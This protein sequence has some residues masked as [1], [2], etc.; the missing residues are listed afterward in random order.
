M[1]VR[2]HISLGG[3]EYV[4]DL[5]GYKRRDIIDFSPR[6]SAPGGSVYSEL[7]LYQTLN[8]ENFQGGFGYPWHSASHPNVY[9]RTEGNIDTRHSNA[10]QLF[11][12]YT[13]SDSDVSADGFIEFGGD[14]WAYS[15]DGVQKYV[16]SGAAWSSDALTDSVMDM[17]HNGYYLFAARESDTIVYG[18]TDAA[19]DSDWTEAGLDTDQKGAKWIQHHD[20][21]VYAGKHSASEGHL[22]FYDDSIILSSMHL[23]SSDDPTAIP[24]GHP[25]MQVEKPISYR[26][27]FLGPRPDGLYRMDNTRDGARVVID[28]R[29]QTSTAN[30][31]SL[32]VHNGQL[33]Y[34][35]RDELWQWNGVRTVPI[36]P[37]KISHE[38][39]Y[40]TYGEFDNF[41]VVGRFLFMTAKTSHDTY[42]IHILCYDGV[43]WHKM[44]EPITDGSSTIGAMYYDPYNNYLWFDLNGEACYIPFRELSDYAYDDYPV[45]GSHALITSKI[46]A[47]YKRVVKSTPSVIMEGDNC[48]TG[49]YLELSYM[50]DND[51]GWKAWGADSGVTNVLTS[52]G[53][54][55][56]DDPLGTG[57]T[58]LEYKNISYRVDFVSSDSTGTPILE[59]L[60]PRVLM[61]PD[62]LY[63]WSIT[64]KAAEAAQF[65][66]VVSDKTAKEIVDELKAFRDS[67][68][69]LP[70]VDIYEDEYQVYVSSV[71]ENA[72]EYHVDRPGIAPDVE[73]TVTI[74]LVQVG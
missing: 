27:D 64:V 41:V 19:A 69:P 1:A 49:H 45:T 60:Y 30:F 74:N 50:L 34:P 47:G 66:T 11:T 33:V 73:E 58:T 44:M 55:V 16:S 54:K 68:A 25:G 62:T 42:E 20:G 29:D 7:G 38:H 40:V 21:F 17:W 36:T 53:V 35:I 15:T 6:V 56:F 46:A 72:V 14:I 57:E 23:I 18:G 67:K 65:G 8:L 22:V 4:I 2:G 37:P 13:L 43:G 26:G 39:P 10:V 59:G 3:K 5:R 61:R 51:T 63:G 71:T 9:L 52:D 32:A 28:Y 48:T 24:F 12:N 31:R 70:F